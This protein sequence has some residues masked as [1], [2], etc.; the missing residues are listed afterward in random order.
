MQI[1]SPNGLFDSESIDDYDS[2]SI[3]DYLRIVE[4]F[5]IY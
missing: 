4:K 1:T 3:D 2:E 5:A